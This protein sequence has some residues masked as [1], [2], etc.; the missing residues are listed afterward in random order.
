MPL[1]R[2]RGG[3]LVSGPRRRQ[4]PRHDR[5][6]ADE[7]TWSFRHPGS[8]WGQ[9]TVTDAVVGLPVPYRVIATTFMAH[10]WLEASPMNRCVIACGVQLPLV[11]TVNVLAGWCAAVAVI[12]KAVTRGPR[13][14]I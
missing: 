7:T 10:L 5:E 12:R 2:D 13:A 1:P 11:V 3:K 14:E 6:H 4:L 8:P 9:A